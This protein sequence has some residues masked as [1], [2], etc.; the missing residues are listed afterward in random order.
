MKRSSKVNKVGGHVG[1]YKKAERNRGKKKSQ[2]TNKGL[3]N[4]ASA[5]DDP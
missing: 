1:A 5:S 2:D 3:S 4:L